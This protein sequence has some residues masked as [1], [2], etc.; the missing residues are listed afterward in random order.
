M[1]DKAT[2]GT[3][4]FRLNDA[5]RYS[6][7]TRRDDRIRRSGIVHV[8]EQLHL[9]IWTLGTVFLDEVGLRQRRRSCRMVKLRRVARTRP[10]KGR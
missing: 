10:A 6:R 1:P 8:G 2:L 4:A 3:L 5:R 9:E 7:R